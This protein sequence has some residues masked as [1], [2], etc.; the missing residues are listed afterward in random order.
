MKQETLSLNKGSTFLKGKNEQF[1]TRRIAS[2]T[3]LI[4]PQVTSQ[5]PSL[6]TYDIMGQEGRWWGWAG[7]CRPNHE[8]TKAEKGRMKQ[9]KSV[10]ADRRSSLIRFLGRMTKLCGMQ[11]RGEREVIKSSAMRR[12]GKIDDRRGEQGWLKNPGRPSLHLFLSPLHKPFL[13]FSCYSTTADCT[14]LV[15]WRNSTNQSEERSQRYNIDVSS[16]YICDQWHTKYIPTNALDT[17]GT[18]I[19]YTRTYTHT[20][21][22][23]GQL[24]SGRVSHISQ[25][26]IM[27][28]CTRPV[29]NHC[30]CSV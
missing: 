18:C 5:Q 17:N 19:D 7:G 8:W 13:K 16:C 30:L 29:A 25:R 3:Q 28:R 9:R 4:W 11:R 20:A 12:G 10:Q 26:P 24:A 6:L 21:E 1:T 14:L 27:A 22:E 2:R 23:R 15:R